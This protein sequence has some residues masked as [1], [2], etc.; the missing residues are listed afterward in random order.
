M[1]SCGVRLSH[2]CMLSKRI[3]T[4]SKFFHHWI[5]NSHAQNLIS[6]SMSRC[7]S[8]RNIS[9]KF[10][11]AFLSN[12]ANRQTDR[13]TWVKTFTSSI[14]G[15][16]KHTFTHLVNYNTVVVLCCRW[17]SVLNN[18]K[19]QV[20]MKAFG[21]TPNSESSPYNQ[22]VKELTLTILQ[23]VRRL[24]GNQVCCDCGAPGNYFHFHSL[25][26]SRLSVL[27]CCVL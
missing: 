7:L 12:L 5:A 9:S 15:G 18:A 6:S 26:Y 19:E 3:N 17:I 14:V 20:L 22:G 8:T 27:F 10:M 13:Q 21:D 4:S 25:G 16:N 2:S 23:Q 24:P 1:P 11:H